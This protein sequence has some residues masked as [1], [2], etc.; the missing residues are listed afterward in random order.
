MTKWPENW[1][2][3][4]RRLRAPVG[5]VWTQTGMST[6]RAAERAA[7]RMLVDT[8]IIPAGAALNAHHA[9][10][11]SPVGYRYLVTGGT[12]ERVD[13]YAVWLGVE[14]FT[15]DC[16]HGYGLMR[17]SCP[18]CDADQERPHLADPVRVWPAWAKRPLT[19]CRRCAL[20]PS[21][22]VHIA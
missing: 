3:Y 2:V 20:V 13:A 6:R 9:L 4:R 14:R 18:G 19:R 12:G 21:A 11:A 16:A 10:G 15:P 1:T 7:A 17:D 5:E 8:G 22:R